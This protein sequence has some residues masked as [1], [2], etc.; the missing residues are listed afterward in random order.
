MNGDVELLNYIYQNSKMGKDSTQ[1]LMEISKNDKFNKL[2]NSQF[3]E[4]KKYL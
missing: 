4:C 2:L 3:E 1:Q